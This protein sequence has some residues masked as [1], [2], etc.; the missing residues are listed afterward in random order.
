MSKRSVRFWKKKKCIEYRL[1]LSSIF[2]FLN[3]ARILLTLRLLLQPEGNWLQNPSDMSDFFVASTS[4]LSSQPWCHKPIRFPVGGKRWGIGKNGCFL[5]SGR[6]GKG[7]GV[8]LG[9]GGGCTGDM[10]TGGSLSVCDIKC[11]AETWKI[12]PPRCF[13]NIQMSGTEQTAFPSSPLPSQEAF[14][15]LALTSGLQQVPT[16]GF[17]IF[18]LNLTH[19]WQA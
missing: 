16:L 3:K 13:R 8:C 2:C 14:D 12:Q 18:F 6:G 11:Q 7:L 5:P 17:G 10:G 4:S 15:I 1:S 19:G 9:G